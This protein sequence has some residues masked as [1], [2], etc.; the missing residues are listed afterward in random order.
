VYSHAKQLG[1]ITRVRE[2]DGNQWEMSDVVVECET[3]V[4]TATQQETGK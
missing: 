4:T 1:V 3:E 2:G